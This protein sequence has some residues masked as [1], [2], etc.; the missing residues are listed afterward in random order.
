[1]DIEKVERRLKKII[2]V[3]DAFK[4]DGKISNIEKDLLLGYIRDLYEL[5]KE[6]E[7]SNVPAKVSELLKADIPAP[8]VQLPKETLPPIQDFLA[9]TKVTE[10]SY[11]T[12]VVQLPETIVEP[13][14]SVTPSSN[15][16]SHVAQI[17]TETLEEVI[18]EPVKEIPKVESVTTDVSPEMERLFIINKAVDLSDKLAMSKIEDISKAMGINERLFNLNELFGGNMELFNNT[19]AILNGMSSFSE[20]RAHLINGVAK[21]MRWDSDQKWNK[22]HQFV[23]LISRRYQ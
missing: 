20:A 21:D 1:M 10:I 13:V 22:A 19:I 18:S 23:R 4:E 12:P 5:V 16:S 14:L 9:E 6:S 8:A 17:K 7:P 2:T 3:F 15:G 11:E